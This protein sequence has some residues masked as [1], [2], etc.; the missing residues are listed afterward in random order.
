MDAKFWS[1][2]VPVLGA[3]VGFGL[4]SGWAVGY[5]AKK[6]MLLLALAVGLVFVVIQV[7][8]VS[9]LLSVNWQG[10]AASFDRLTHQ[11]QGGHS[12]LWSVL[13]Y[14]FPYAGAFA[15]GFALGF[16]KG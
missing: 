15:V 6:L 2:Y 14:N 4:V 5:L 3:G 8:V 11:V 12:A 9:R 13:V 7:M 16:K 10:V 1:D